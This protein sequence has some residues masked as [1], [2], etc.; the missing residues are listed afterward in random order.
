MTDK[1]RP[2][3]FGGIYRNRENPNIFAK[4][5]GFE[6]IGFSNWVKF[7]VWNLL[8]PGWQGGD[9]GAGLRLEE[10]NDLYPEKFDGDVGKLKP[11]IK[12]RMQ[13]TYEYW[14]DPEK[15]Q[16][17]YR[18]TNR[19]EIFRIDKDNAW[20]LMLD[21]L[22]SSDDV[23]ITAEDITEERRPLTIEERDKGFDYDSSDPQYHPV[24]CTC[25]FCI[26][27]A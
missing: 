3:E 22:N 7:G 10:F 8:H 6:R 5:G 9:Q 25:I 1:D 4:V 27:G 15:A 23:V 24:D 20:E 19:A 17:A 13:A 12:I 26:P 14:V 21:V 2:L 18:T 11:C 16:K